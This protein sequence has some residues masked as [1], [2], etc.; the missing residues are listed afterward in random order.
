MAN[1]IQIKRA[2][3]TSSTAPSLSEGELAYNEYDKELFIGTSGSS[4][5]TIGGKIGETVQSLV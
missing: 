3:S 1:T 2:A 5:Q 4:L